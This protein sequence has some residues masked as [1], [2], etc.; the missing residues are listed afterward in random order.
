MATWNRRKTLLVV[1]ILSFFLLAVGT[2]LIAKKHAKVV[3]D[4]ADEEKQA[5]SSR[6]R[7]LTTSE[8]QESSGAKK[9]LYGLPGSAA[10]WCAAPILPPLPYDQCKK[11]QTINSVPLYGG[12]T[13]SLKMVLLGTILSFEQDRCFFVDES[14]SEL[15]KRGDNQQALDSFINRYFEPIGLARSDPL[16]QRAVANHNVEVQDWTKVWENT[17]ARRMYGQ[18][19][20]IPSL[21]Y[22][23][24]EGHQLKRVMLRRMWRPLP[25]VRH[26]TCRG[27]AQHDLTDDFMTFS[28]RRGD[29]AT[30]ENFS[31][32]SVQQYI[33]GAER[34]IPDHFGGR[35]PTI[36]VA[37]DDCTVLPEFRQ[38]RP[39]WK[40]VSECDSAQQVKGHAGFALA[41][42]TAWSQ[43]DTDAHYRKFFIE[44][45]AMAI[46]KYFI[47]VWYT[48]GTLLLSCVCFDGVCVL[49]VL[50]VCLIVVCRL[51][52][53]GLLS[54]SPIVYVCFV[55]FLLVLCVNSPSPSD[56]IPSF[57]SVVV[58]PIHERARSKHVFDAG[59]TRNRWVCLGLELKKW[60]R[61]KSTTT[62]SAV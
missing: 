1:E 11:K 25:H 48:N 28:V 21:G 44:L 42:M 52:L 43:A 49:L 19:S 58:C 22:P 45:Y 17:G 50:M 15:I 61:S 24:T 8:Q 39:S 53:C 10:E 4:M 27:L 41:E 56:T 38:L 16:V 7:R 13:N 54:N 6:R 57:C 3:G 60:S 46:S 31:Y 29:K 20:S 62:S 30:E 18:T 59:Y 32:A 9:D 26:E 47:G 23:L 5:S 55:C 14:E 36:F 33:D 37:T 51:V 34:A 35:V 12:L 2:L 40:F